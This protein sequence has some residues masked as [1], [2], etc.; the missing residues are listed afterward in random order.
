MEAGNQETNA[1]I[2]EE[3]RMCCSSIWS[4][5]IPPKIKTFWWRMAH[6]GIAVLDNLRRRGV[7]MDNTCPVCEEQT[8]TLNHADHIIH[9]VNGALRDLDQWREAKTNTGEEEQNRQN[10][11]PSKILIEDKLP[12]NSEYYCLVDASWKSSREEMG[13]GWSL[14]RREGTQIMHGSSAEAPMNSTIEA[15][16]IALLMATQQMVRLNY[17]KVALGG[18]KSL[19]DELNQFKTE[20]T[21]RNFRITEG[22]FVLQDILEISRHR[23][24]TFHYISRDNLNVVDSLAKQARLHKKNYVVS[25][26]F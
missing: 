9:M 5:N 6:G 8:E 2:S 26:K 14:H 16:A 10:K 4:L 17:S 23:D 1:V 19:F 20:Q 24:Y 12:P 18:C 7:K 25:W 11:N 15:E 3:V 13:F 22:A 21:I